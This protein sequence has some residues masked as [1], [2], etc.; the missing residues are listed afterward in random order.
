ML[1][2][3]FRLLVLAALL[4]LAAWAVSRFLNREEDFE[5]YED[6]DSTLDFIETP[7]EIDVPYDSGTASPAPQASAQTSTAENGAAS[8]TVTVAPVREE[9]PAAA[10]E[11]ASAAKS[12]KG[13][14]G[15]ATADSGSIIDV[16][17]IGPTY[18]ARLKEIGVNSLADLARADADDIAGKIE[19]IGGRNEVQDWIDQAKRM[20]SSAA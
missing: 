8:D 19:V 3:L 1:S 6:I 10:S 5:D 4:A 9:T 16:N 13:S 18:A 7:V 15:A 20:T 14:A 2:R 12:G 11:K 17:G